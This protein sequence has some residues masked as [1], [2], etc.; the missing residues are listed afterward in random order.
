MN[1]K[2]QTV[3]TMAIVVPIIDH[4][5]LDSIEDYIPCEPLYA[6]AYVVFQWEPDFGNF[7]ESDLPWF[8]TEAEA[9]V[10]AMALHIQTC[11]KGGINP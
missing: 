7:V 2:M 8:E 5:G 10:A 3:E 11:L 9:R 1:A 6:V 4:Y